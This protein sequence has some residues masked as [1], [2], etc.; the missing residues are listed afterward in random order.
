MPRVSSPPVRVPPCINADLWPT[1]TQLRGVLLSSFGES[2][3]QQLEVLLEAL[4]DNSSGTHALSHAPPPQSKADLVQEL[5]DCAMDVAGPSVEAFDVARRAAKAWEE[6]ESAAVAAAE[7][8]GAKSELQLMAGE[9]VTDAD[10]ETTNEAATAAAGVDVAAGEGEGMAPSPAEAAATAAAAAAVTLREAEAAAKRASAELPLALHIELLKACH[11][12]EAWTL[13]EKV[14]P[15]ASLRTEQALAQ[16][17]VE[18]PMRSAAETVMHAET[19]INPFDESLAATRVPASVQGAQDGRAPKGSPRGEWGLAKLI[20]A[21]ERDAALRYAEVAL[22]K[23]GRQIE[24]AQ[25]TRLQLTPCPSRLT[26]PLRTSVDCHVHMTHL[27]MF[28]V[29]CLLGTGTRVQGCGRGTGGAAEPRSD[30]DQIV[31]PTSCGYDYSDDCGWPVRRCTHL[32]EI[33]GTNPEGTR[34]ARGSGVS[35]Q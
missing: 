26:H 25:A 8:E 22:I 31:R 1:L 7:A 4:R 20:G 34:R 10:A 2:T 14:L 15:S 30:P 27:W 32:V 29:A 13:M 3:Q 9:G 33:C 12:H 35:R 16:H 24:Q 5:L 28:I 19:K 17:L 23:G 11:H 6:A 18:R 21:A